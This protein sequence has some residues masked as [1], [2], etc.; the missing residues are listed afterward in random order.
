[1]GR[2]KCI[3]MVRRDNS[4]PWIN[5]FS[6]GT[7]NRSYSL[8]YT[9]EDR[10]ELNAF[11]LARVRD[12]EDIIAK[13]MKE[14]AAAELSELASPESNVVPLKTRLMQTS[15]EFVAGFMPPDYL[16]DGLLQR[17]YVY[18]LTGPT[19]SGKTAIALLIALHV[20]LGR[21]LAEREVEKGRVLFFAG[22]NPDDVRS[23]WIK[24][25]E[26]MDEDPDMMDVV[27]MPFTLH[28]LR[29]QNPQAHRCRS[30]RARTVQPA[31]RRYQRGLL[32]RRR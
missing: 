6:H 24:L 4:W 2:D 30:R 27:F 20:A 15:A 22:E 8:M 25:C 7:D 11:E 32:H 13:L 17:R 28:T 18:S 1:M 19:G 16:I 3:V 9:E 14:K 5:V 21:S 23:R 26:E 12:A 10:A 29:R 31:D